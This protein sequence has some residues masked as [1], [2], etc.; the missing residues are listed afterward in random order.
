MLWCQ[1]SVAFS[2]LTTYF[3]DKRK[4]SAPTSVHGL[5]LFGPWQ[6]EQWWHVT[7]ILWHPKDH[8]LAEKKVARVNI[9]NGLWQ[10]LRREAIT[11]ALQRKWFICAVI[12]KTYLIKS[13]FDI[14]QV[15]VPT[16]VQVFVSMLHCPTISRNVE[17]VVAQT[18]FRGITEN[19]Q[20]KKKCIMFES[21]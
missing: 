15:I 16:P 13:W 7:H 4:G 12:S 19:L 10:L 8:D 14:K 3:W 11:Q 6:Q 17:A 20:N 21:H 1:F 5:H 18:F 2:A 9:Y